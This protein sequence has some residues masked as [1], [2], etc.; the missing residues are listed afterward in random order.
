MSVAIEVVAVPVASA[1]AA[2]RAGSG[3]GGI[4]TGDPG[5]FARALAE[6][7]TPAAPA[8]PVGT[9]A[10][11]GA[12]D[13]AARASSR[14]GKVHRT[15]AKRARSA[16]T[17]VPAAPSTR[18]LP[19]ATPPA[20][21]LP[22]QAPRA[23]AGAGTEAGE[24]RRRTGAAS[25]TGV[26][27]DA[28][29]AALPAAQARPVTTPLP[30]GVGDGTAPLRTGA[31][32]APAPMGAATGAATNQTPTRSG[33]ARGVVAPTRVPVGTAP[34]TTARPTP[35]PSGTAA[36]VPLRETP[37]TALPEAAP[38][39]PAP[40]GVSRAAV[41]APQAGRLPAPSG[42]AGGSASARASAEGSVAGPVAGPSGR[43]RVRR[44]GAALRP[45]DG[46][47]GLAGGGTT[48]PDGVTPAPAAG[49]G[50][51]MAVAPLPTPQ[52]PA[53]PT[54]PGRVVL[55]IDGGADG[56]VRATVTARGS[57]VT[58]RLEA[59]GATAAN[60]AGG[61]NELV[62][63][64]AARGLPAQ[65]SVVR[66][67]AG[68]VQADGGG[69]GGYGSGQE[70]RGGDGRGEAGAPGTGEKTFTLDTRA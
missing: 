23:L 61:L 53:L 65:A 52:E 2:D 7:L 26:L 31:A 69:R 37:A 8:A 18:V 60:L 41:P 48:A 19:G 70:G 49:D 67:D 5:A 68:A 55:A 47:G 14:P 6:R 59:G 54:P 34:G 45:T 36:A 46:Q 20:T 43:L 62:G 63:S 32:P 64:L 17:V 9:T 24:G 66:T 28:R 51:A 21:L 30:I 1:P 4:G 10:A 50:A 25:V 56:D 16:K 38:T 11:G 12:T 29:A 44:P 35:A 22:A 33:S 40:A 13:P 42:A 39:A 3:T 57:Q 15:L 58:A 27:R